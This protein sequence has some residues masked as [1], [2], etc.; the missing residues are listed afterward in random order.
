MK[1]LMLMFPNETCL[2]DRF[3][4]D[5]DANLLLLLLL[6]TMMIMVMMIIIMATICNCNDD[7]DY[8]YYCEDYDHVHVDVFYQFTSVQNQDFLMRLF[9]IL[10]GLSMTFVCRR[11]LLKGFYTACLARR[12]A[13]YQL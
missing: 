13:P 12:W 9:S 5:D 10:G 4:D 3:D 6:M 8:D 7:G 2:F 11:S 1:D